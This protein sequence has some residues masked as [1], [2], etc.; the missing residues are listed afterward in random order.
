MRKRVLLSYVV[1]RLLYLPFGLLGLTLLCFWLMEAA[2]GDPVER[3]MRTGEGRA[4]VTA[5][6]DYLSAYRQAASRMGRD[7][8]PFYFTVTHRA[9]PDTLYRIPIAAHRRTLRALAGRSGN[10]PVVQEY[11]RHLRELAFRVTHPPE[12]QA[13]ARKLLRR[14]ED[15]YIRQQ[16]RSLP[17]GTA[18][19]LLL[20]YDK[21]QQEARPLRVLRPRVVWHGTDNRYHHYLTGLL[22]GDW[23]R[24]LDDRRPVVNKVAVALPRTL[25]LNGLALLLIYLLAV[26]T[27]MYMARYAGSRFDRWGTVLLFLAFGIPSFWV[28]TLLANFLTTPA[29][30]MDW[31]PSMGFGNPPPEAG[32]WEGLRIRAAHLVLPV[33]CL[34]YPGLVYVARHLRAAAL[35]ELRKP[36]VRNAYMQGLSESEVLW[37][38]VFR[39]ASFPLITLLGYLLPALL[40][41]SVLIERIFNLPGMGM[42][43]YDAALGDDWPVLTALILL[44]G[45]LTISGILIADLVYA[46]ADPRVRLG[47]S[48]R[49]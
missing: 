18:R 14:S 25:L 39:N 1:R 42:L 31:F 9:V 33:F 19:E 6:E 47:T 48:G 43:L 46:L 49:R 17:D 35:E 45:L 5:A 13:T 37:G 28:A 21:L 3:R 40:A 22:A 32:W 27:G 26:P 4:A 7:R 41:G 8:P 44:N 29:Y 20:R 16:I 15:G 23:G 38:H 11:Y 34:V 12:V 36:Y 24:S 10:W 2:T 30:G